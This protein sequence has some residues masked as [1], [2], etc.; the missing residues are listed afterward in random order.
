MLQRVAP[1]LN[2]LL[3]SESQPRAILNALTTLTD[4]KVLSSPSLVALDN[5][6]ALLQVGD[7]IPIT[8][9]SA[10]VLAN[11]AAP[12]VNT[13]QMRNTGVILKVLPHINANGSILLEVDQEISNVVNPDQQTLT[14]TIAQ[15]RV[16]S[17]VSV[18]S[19]QT[20]LLAGLISERN[21]QT[22]SGV[23]G[24]R[25]IKI[26]GDVFGNTSNTKSR[27]EIIIFIKT[28]LIRNSLDASA[29]TEEFRERLQTM[30]GGRTVINGTDAQR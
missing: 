4:V 10:A 11:S 9:S 2:L 30:R 14:P 15:R 7:E 5:Q 20:V 29:V 21:Q 18:T 6:P 17:T 19:G 3:G 1:G 13:I 26:L 27:S 28:K 8:T 16:H 23:P 22:R 12:I 24:L 25:E